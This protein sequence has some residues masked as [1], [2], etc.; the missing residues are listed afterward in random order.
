M[1]RFSKIWGYASDGA[2]YRRWYVHA[3]I[4]VG[5]LA[6]ET[7]Q[8]VGRVADVLAITSPKT[9]V[10]RNLRVTREYLTTGVLPRDVIGST[11]RALEHYETTGEIRG[12]KTSRFAKALRGDNNVCV[13][14]SHMARAFGYRAGDAR[15]VRVQ[16]PIE[17]RLRRVG[18]VNGWTLAEAQA[19]VWAGYYKAT[20]PTGTVPLYAVQ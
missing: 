11:R 2:A 1:R 15:L 19:A 3:R 14:D 9:S 10:M 13:V 18:R 12:P 20:Y 5:K 7:G 8:P 17:R 16:K 4:I 6:A